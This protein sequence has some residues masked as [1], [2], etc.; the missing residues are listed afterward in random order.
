MVTHV[1]AGLR[2]PRLPCLLRVVD[3]GSELRFGVL[4]FSHLETGLRMAILK[5]YGVD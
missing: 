1:D 5:G 2:R 4:R 3:L